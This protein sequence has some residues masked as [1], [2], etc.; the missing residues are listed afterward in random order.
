MA[1]KADLPAVLHTPTIGKG[2]A[3]YVSKSTET[4]STGKP[5]LQSDSAKIDGTKIAVEVADE[6]G[7]PENRLV[8]THA[9][10][11]TA[12][13]ILENTDCYASFTVGNERRDVSFDDIYSAIETYGPD[14]ILV[15]TDSAAIYRIDPFDVKRLILDLLGDGIDREDVRQVVYGNQREIL[16]LDHL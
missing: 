12:P 2:E 13:W 1:D 5:V 4:H 10:R 15:D 7:F 14:R 9:H 6:A 8:L 11:S 16:G 3:D